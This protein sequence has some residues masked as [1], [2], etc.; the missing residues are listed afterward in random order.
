VVGIFT[1]FEERPEQKGGP[2]DQGFSDQQDQST[3]GVID[4]EEPDQRGLGSS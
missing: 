1:E 2:N 3:D 4:I